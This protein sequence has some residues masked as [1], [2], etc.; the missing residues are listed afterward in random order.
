GAGTGQGSRCRARVAGRGGG[1]SCPAGSPRA[2]ARER[3]AVGAADGGLHAPDRAPS[4]GLVPHLLAPQR[5]GSLA[6][7]PGHRAAD[8]GRPDGPVLRESAPRV[9][10][11]RHHCPWSAGVGVGRSARARPAAYLATRNL[12]DRPGVAA[13]GRSVRAAPLLPLP[14]QL[15]H[16]RPS[17]LPRKRAHA[18]Q[19][20]QALLGGMGRPRAV[21]LPD[22]RG[23]AR[24]QPGRWPGVHRPVLRARPLRVPPRL[25]A[26]L[27]CRAD[28]ARAAGGPGARRRHRRGRARR[29]RTELRRGPLL[30]AAHPD[31][32]PAADGNPGPAPSADPHHGDG[33]CP[34]ADGDKCRRGECHGRDCDPDRGP[35][36]SHRHA[37]LHAR[38]DGS[39]WPPRGRQADRRGSLGPVSHRLRGGRRRLGRLYQQRQ[40]GLGDADRHLQHLQQAAGGGHARERPGAGGR[41]LLPARRPLGDVLRR[42]RLRHPRRL[43]AQRLRLATQPRLRRSAGRRGERPLRLGADRHDRLH[44]LL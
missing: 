31:A 7:Q 29:G 22:Q 12:A 19:Q 28:T 39:G 8:R 41:G 5:A 43:L 3:G 34:L 6:R 4:G 24:G 26:Q 18:G 17:L 23:A 37:D 27:G 33:E 15:Q 32:D 14:G 25:L 42:R 30:A 16:R 13:R 21:R 9:S 20:L 2:G 44:P 36:A 35:P 38:G 10:P 11:G 40:A 1:N